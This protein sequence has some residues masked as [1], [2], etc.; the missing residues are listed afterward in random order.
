MLARN[1]DLEQVV[2]SLANIAIQPNQNAKFGFCE[3]HQTPMKLRKSIFIYL[4][5]FRHENIDCHSHLGAF[6]QPPC[7]VSQDTSSY[8]CSPANF[9][10]GR[11]NFRAIEMNPI[12]VARQWLANP[13]ILFRNS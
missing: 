9:F 3:R 11:C 8:N 1:F 5:Q 2:E 7:I 10:S 12:L 6:W 13:L 4:S